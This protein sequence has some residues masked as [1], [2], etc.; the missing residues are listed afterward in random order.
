[1]S[2]HNA[3][4]D[5]DSSPYLYNTTG[6]MTGSGGC[7]E[8]MINST[9]CQWKAKSDKSVIFYTADWQA[10]IKSHDMNPVLSF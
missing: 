3:I 8:R 9:H 1:M 4:N 2:Y 7:Y 6:V 10:F 5:I